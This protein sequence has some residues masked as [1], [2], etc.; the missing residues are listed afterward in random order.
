MLF[1]NAVIEV[2]AD[3]YTQV[4]ALLKK[5]IDTNAKKG[6]INKS[7][8]FKCRLKHDKRGIAQFGSALGSGPRGRRFKSGFPDLETN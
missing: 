7:L 6:Y 5:D 3:A 4:R 1:L 8:I 2:F